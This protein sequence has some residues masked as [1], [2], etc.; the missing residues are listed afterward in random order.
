MNANGHTM[1]PASTV[2]AVTPRPSTGGRASTRA[3]LGRGVARG[4]LPLLGLAL[5]GGSTAGLTILAWQLTSG[6]GFFAR[7]DISMAIAVVGL[8][9]TVALYAV[10]CKRALRRVARWQEGGEIA[11]AIGG[12]AAVGL[13]ALLVLLP[14]ILAVVIPQHPAP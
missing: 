9:V 2:P 11:S 14:V 8:I 5:T 13:T 7:R 3:A 4:L 10:M 12:L 1:S 6:L